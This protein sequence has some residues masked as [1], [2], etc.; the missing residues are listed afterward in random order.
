MTQRK[1]RGGDVKGCVKLQ[2]Q[3]TLPTSAYPTVPALV[4]WLVTVAPCPEVG[5]TRYGYACVQETSVPWHEQSTHTN[6][7]LCVFERAQ[8]VSL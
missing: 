2:P 8:M 4:S 1:V 6:S 7:Y 5:Y 3:G